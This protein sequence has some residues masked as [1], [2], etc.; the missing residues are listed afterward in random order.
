MTSASDWPNLC[1]RGGPA[2]Q[3]PSKPDTSGGQCGGGPHFKV[4]PTDT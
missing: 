1:D 4:A 3:V 2:P